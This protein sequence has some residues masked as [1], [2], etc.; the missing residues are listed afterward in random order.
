MCD[1]ELN[2][3]DGLLC[4]ILGPTTPVNDS[5][6]ELMSATRWIQCRLR[7]VVFALRLTISQVSRC[8]VTLGTIDQELEKCVRRLVV[9]VLN[10]ALELL[11]IA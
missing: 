1:Q 8:R 4:C 5:H 10:L 2:M 9:V 3:P 11:W 7:P 6:D